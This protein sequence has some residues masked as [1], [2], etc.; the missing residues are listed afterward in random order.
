FVDK[1]TIEAGGELYRAEHIVIATGSK[2]VIPDEWRQ[3]KE[4]L[5]DTDQFFELEDLP[6]RI[7]II[8][9]GVIGIELGQAINRLGISTIGITKGREFGGLT[10]PEI[11]NSVFSMLCQ[12]FPVDDTGVETLSEKKENGAR[13]LQIKTQKD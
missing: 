3:F 2:P 11:Q 7:A 10:D 9:L 13:V 6:K 12:E 5:V 1:Q 4:L 8:G